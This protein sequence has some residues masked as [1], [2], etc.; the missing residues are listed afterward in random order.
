MKNEKKFSKY[1]EWKNPEEMHFSCLEWISYL[2]FI[3]DENKFFED[4]LKEFTL[5]V[6]EAHLFTRAKELV[7]KL[8]LV[9]QQEKELTKKLISHRKNLEIMVDGV[10]EPQ[11]EEQYKREHR[12]LK[13][14]V[15]QYTE[16][17]RRLKK[18]IFEMVSISLKKQKQKNLLS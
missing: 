5:P 7:N 1:I 17:Y 8:S 15:S 10:D 11:F 12:E 9:E 6:L 4:L 18:E 2:D 13:N 16:S 3:R 14:E